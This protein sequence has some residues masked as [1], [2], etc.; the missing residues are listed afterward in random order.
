M[1][2]NK[3][4]SSNLSK[5]LFPHTEVYLVVGIQTNL[6][7]TFLLLWLHE[8]VITHLQ[9]RPQMEHWVHGYEVI[10]FCWLVMEV[11]NFQTCFLKKS[12]EH[13]G[14]MAVLL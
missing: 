11:F 13:K 12:N 14:I 6:E 5:L 1:V 4:V 7:E 8:N 3:T 2:L 9:K 10:L